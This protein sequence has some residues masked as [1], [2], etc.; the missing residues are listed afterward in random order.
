MNFKRSYNLP[1]AK[2]NENTYAWSKV[3][4]KYILSFKAL[5][6][7]WI[8]ILTTLFERFRLLVFLDMLNVAW[9]PPVMNANKGHLRNTK[10][11]FPSNRFKSVFSDIYVPK[12]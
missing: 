2:R 5:L 6:K 7:H 8:V 11:P 9:C 4:N 3:L 12:C 10:I 1:C